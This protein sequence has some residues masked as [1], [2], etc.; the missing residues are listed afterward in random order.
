MGPRR[1]GGRCACAAKAPEAAAR[2]PWSASPAS[3]RWRCASPSRARRARDAR[4]LRAEHVGL[5]GGVRDAQRRSRAARARACTS[6]IR[7]RSTARSASGVPPTLRL[8]RAFSAP[9]TVNRFERVLVWCH[10]MWFMVPHGSVL[11]VLLRDRER[12]P[13]AAARMYAV[14]DLGAVFYWAIP[15][16]PP[17]W[18]AQHGDLEDA[19]TVADPADDDRVRRAVL[20]RPLERPLRCPRRKSACC[21]AVAPFRHVSDGR[22]PARGGRA[23]RGRGRAG[24][25][26]AML[27]LALVYLGEHYVADLIA[28]AALA[29][30]VRLQ[31]PRTAL[32]GAPRLAGG[33]GARSPGGGGVGPP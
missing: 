28:G 8:Q 1:G 30:T 15:T 17:W 4:G 23:G 27:G 2:R 22:T 31:A 33:A 13:S 19:Q 16:A 3:L 5:P 12:F 11:Y 7:S 10:W 20:G 14:F 25:T 6:A 18:A 9:G 21:H 32:A 24:R 26:S 29:E